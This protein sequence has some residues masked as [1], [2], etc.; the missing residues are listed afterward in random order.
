MSGFDKKKYVITGAH[1]DLVSKWQTVVVRI[2]RSGIR[3]FLFG[4][5]SKK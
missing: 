5:Y 2:E 1:S 3:T 4:H